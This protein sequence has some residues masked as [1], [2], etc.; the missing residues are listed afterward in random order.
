[1]S[2][3]VVV[4]LVGL[5]LASCASPPAAPAATVTPRPAATATPVPAPPDLGTIR[6]FDIA[7]L[8]VR[9]VPLLMAMDALRAQG[10]TVEVTYLAKSSLIA[11]AL[12]EG[13]AD[14]GLLN[15]QTMWAAVA[16]GAEVRT[17]AEPVASTTVLVAQADVTSCA[18]LH[19]QPVGVASTTGL[20]PARLEEYLRQNCP[21]AA[22][23][24]LVISES[25][26]RAAGLLSGELRAALLPAEEMLK[27]EA[28]APGKLHALA[29][30]AKTYPDVRQDG[31]HVRT[32]WGREH[33]QAVRDLLRAMLLANRQVLDSPDLL[34]EEAMRRLE[35][36][37]ATAEAV[38]NLHLGLGVFDA[39]GALSEA[40]VQ[41]TLDFLVGIEALP[42]G[43]RAADVADLSYLNAVLDALGRRQGR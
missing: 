9:D 3:W 1:V 21:G 23:K 17:I 18:Q 36:D 27:L 35:L 12:A 7:N 34:G 30:M 22:P 32:A 43:L 24:Y 10:Y 16:K 13:D 31:L 38:A 11:A 37:A 41:A 40:R 26:G 29:D 25:A 33:A 20:S 42:P 19:D 5:C 4:L 2:K 6:F 8:D 15:N 39:N 14:I 28:E